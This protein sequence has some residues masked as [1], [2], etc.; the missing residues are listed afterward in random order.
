MT[1]VKVPDYTASDRQTVFHTTVADEKLY[2]GAA[3]GGKTAAIVAEASTLALEYPGI[4]INLFRRT[5]PELNKTIKAEFV[6][7][8]HAYIRSGNIKWQGQ[9][10]GE[11][12]GRTYVYSNGSSITLNY[13]DNEADM[14]RYQ[15]AEMP[16]IGVDELT[17][18]PLA[19]IEYL[20]T[21]NRT[22][23]HDWPVL[24]MAGTNPG[25]IGHGWV[26]SRFIDA[27][28]PEKVFDVRLPDGTI[29][30]RV[31]IPAKLD[32]HPD[33]R[34]RRDYNKQ[35]QSI[36]DPNLRRALRS[37][38]W[39]VFAGQVFTEFS[40]ETH[41][42]EPFAIPDHWRKWRS[43]DYGNKNSILWFAQDPASE[44]VY[45][46]REYRT[47]VYV[48]IG[49]KAKTVSE[50]EAGDNITYGL[51]D[52][53]IWNGSANHNDKEGKSVAQ[54]FQDEGVNWQPAVNDRV[55]GLAMVHHM[56][57]IADDGLPR[58]QFFSSCI[59]VIKTLPS[60][61]YD[62]FKVDDVDTKADDHDYDSLRY[63]VMKFKMK[64][65]PTVRRAG[66]VQKAKRNQGAW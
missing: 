9:A 40:R 18:F 47:E 26:K 21:R 63:G 49:D 24:F 55:A 6:R 23:N 56:L 12:E 54:I 33:E 25:G 19:W 50:L 39:D 11:H 29:K 5:I 14:Y 13:L 37:G 2:G 16:V 38:D 57:G 60:L 3:G 4:P 62:K 42:V 1:Q 44:R 7:Q 59:S 48:T 66:W 41:V 64:A 43:M 31:F 52:P 65:K 35:L 27:A 8:N 61:P 51:A 53:S 45:V 46:Y 32:D 22:S 28:P 36:S 58:L 10:S 30:T 15:G 20:I 17:Q 34:F